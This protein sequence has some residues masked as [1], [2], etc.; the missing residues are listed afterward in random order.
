MT[1]RGRS[2]FHVI[3]LASMIV[4]FAGCATTANYEKILQSWVGGSEDDL[5]QAWGPP[6]SSYP[7]SSGGKVIEYIRR[8]SVTS[9]GYIH[10]VPVTT[11]NNGMVNI[12]GSNGG[13]ANGNYSGT[14]T[15]YVPERSPTYTMHFVCI[16]DFTVDAAGIIRAW[17]WK[18]NACRARADDTGSAENGTQRATDLVKLKQDHGNA[19][20]RQDAN[21]SMSPTSR[22]VNNMEKHDKEER[23]LYRYYINAGSPSK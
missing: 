16:T 14:S 9:G 19:P 3:L 8:S 18:G 10:Y 1:F 4:M 15:T 22:G 21:A 11:N 2:W 5:V 12:Y 20:E 13:Y 23:D 6:Q 7:L 17:S